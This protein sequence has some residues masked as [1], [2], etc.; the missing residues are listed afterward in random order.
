M[1]LGAECSSYIALLND[2]SLLRRTGA[3]YLKFAKDFSFIIWLDSHF[4][5]T[6]LI[7][8]GFVVSKLDQLANCHSAPLRYLV[9]LP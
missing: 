6:K 3:I 4:C 2:A 8:S 7:L 9:P 5:Q 1:A